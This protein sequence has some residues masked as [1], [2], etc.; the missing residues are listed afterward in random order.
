LGTGLILDRNV[1]ST[2]WY[3]GGLFFVPLLIY[4]SFVTLSR[5]SNLIYVEA[6]WC[7]AMRNS[8]TCQHLPPWHVTSVFMVLWFSSLAPKVL[9]KITTL[10]SIVTSQRHRNRSW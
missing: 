2:N 8:F 3:F 4:H 9:S 6:L 5:D 10:R 1:R 7:L